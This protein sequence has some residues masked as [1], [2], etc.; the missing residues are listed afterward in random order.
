[1]DELTRILPSISQKQKDQVD[2]WWA[3]FITNSSN[4]ISSIHEGSDKGVDGIVKWIKSNLQLIHTEIMWEIGP[5]IKKPHRLVITPEFKSYLRP[6]VNYILH[7]APDLDEWEFYGYRLAE[8]FPEAVSVLSTRMDWQDTPEIK[9]DISVE[10]FNSLGITYYLPL[11]TYNDANIMDKLW[12]LTE[13]LL[14]DEVTEKWIQGIDVRLLSETESQQQTELEDASCLKMEIDR[15]IEDIRENLPHKPYSILSENSDYCV[16]DIAPLQNQ[17]NLEKHEL[18]TAYSI[19][20]ELFMAMHQGKETFYSERFSNCGENFMYLK[21]EDSASLL[22][23]QGN[24]DR[25]ILEDALDKEL[26]S[27]KFGCIVGGGTGKRHQYI[28]L[29]ITNSPE[30]AIDSIRKVLREFNL[31]KNSW[32]LFYDLD[33]QN[34]WI[35]V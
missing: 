17:I 35:G 3:N 18:L 4:L 5:G 25:D 34:E 16:F 27:K 33:F 9:F 10:L 31:P 32:I 12:L 14:G 22:E 2:K 30:S 15:R 24:V 28:D 19:S 6:L 26:K 23:R 7:E 13:T 1:M 11:T 20:E 21:I 8:N 29:A